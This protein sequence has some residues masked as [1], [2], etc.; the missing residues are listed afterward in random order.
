MNIQFITNDL[1]TI[2]RVLK[3]GCRWIRF[4]PTDDNRSIAAEAV[5]LCRKH[6]AVIIVEED[7]ELCEAVK[8]D[9]VHLSKAGIAGQ[10]RRQLGEEPLIGVT[11]KDFEDA[12]TARAA[13]AD[14]LDAGAY[15]DTSNESLRALVR[16]LY[17][18]D[19]PLPLSISGTVKPDD[20][21]TVSATG[22]RGIATADEE[23]FKKDIWKII[24]KLS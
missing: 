3:H 24:D 14:Y 4:V 2:R 21:P 20:I 5:S 13:G 8:A 17:E 9:G 19:Y 11:V 18:A 22:V 15:E 16:A 10:V 1:D 6:E 7:A 23:F 12:K